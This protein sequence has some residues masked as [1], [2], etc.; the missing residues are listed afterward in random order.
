MQKQNDQFA[1]IKLVN[2]IIWGFKNEKE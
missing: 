1:P 2:N